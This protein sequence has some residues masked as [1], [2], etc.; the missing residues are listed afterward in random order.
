V[1]RVRLGGDCEWL[2]GLEGA[3]G[4]GQCREGGEERKV[5]EG[6]GRSGERL[7]GVRGESG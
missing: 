3:V 7:G 2:E 1:R 6:I 4:V 5:L